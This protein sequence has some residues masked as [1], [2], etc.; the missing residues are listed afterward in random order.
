MKR[1]Y[2]ASRN[3]SRRF[4]FAGSGGRGDWARG[5]TIRNAKAA[6]IAK[7]LLM[8]CSKAEPCRQLNLPRCGGRRVDAVRRAE[9]RLRL[10]ARG[11]EH[12]RAIDVDELHLVQQIV[13]LA[14]ELERPCAAGF[15][16]LED[17]QVPV[18]GAWPLHRVPGRVAVIA[19][20]R[21]PLEGV[22]VEPA[23]ERIAW[24]GIRVADD[25]RPHVA[26]TAA[27]V[28]GLAPFAAS[29]VE[30]VRRGEEDRRPLAA[31]ERV[32]ARQLPAVEQQ[33]GDAALA[34]RKI[35]HV[36]DAQVVRLA[37]GEDVVVEGDWAIQR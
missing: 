14:A 17:R 18:V 23:G 3:H 35:P 30:V 21:R 10:L 29:E 4:S 5:W 11:V 31:D 13:D 7:T 27:Q 12:R 25:D 6:K 9:R 19:A 1:P 37:V 20:T 26:Q 2:L 32:R 15:E 33:S 16:V 22:D 28:G 8:V 36:V 34:A 24:P